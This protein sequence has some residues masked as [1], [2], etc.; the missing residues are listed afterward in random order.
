PKKKPGRGIRKEDRV[1]RYIIHQTHLLCLLVSVLTRHAVCDDPQ[2]QT[3]VAALLPSRLAEVF[4]RL[5][6]KI[7]QPFLSHMN[8]VARWWSRSLCAKAHAGPPPNRAK[9]SKP[10]RP[11]IRRAADVRT[12]F[13]GVG[14]AIAEHGLRWDPVIHGSIGDPET[15]ALGFV[16]L[17]RRMGV[18]ARLVASLHPVSLQIKRHEQAA[19]PPFVLW[20]E[21]CD[22][23][24]HTWM[25]VHVTQ[26]V[27][28]NPLVFDSGAA[29]D[30]QSQL[31]YIVACEPGR[32]V[33]DVTRRYCLLWGQKTAKLRLPPVAAGI[34]WWLR[35]LRLLSHD[36]QDHADD[37]EQEQFE[38]LSK[39]EAMPTTLAGFRDHPLY[40]IERDLRRH[41]VMHPAGERYGIG[42][43]REWVVY[44]RY[45][46]HETFSRE[47]W[48]RRGMRVRD[49]E[50]PAKRVPARAA[51]VRRQREIVAAQVENARTGMDDPEADP[52]MTALFGSWQ[53]EKLAPPP[54]L[55][56]DPLPRNAFGNFEAFHPNAIPIGAVHI[57]NPGA[58]KVAKRLGIEHVPVVVDF[59]FRSGHSHPVID[60]ILVRDAMVEVLES[61]ADTF[62][63]HTEAEAAKKRR[64]QLH[65]RWRYMYKAVLTRA[66]VMHQY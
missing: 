65:Q 24:S 28:N 14:A 48:A 57:R 21:V 63:E 39:N 4:Q 37:R 42:R 10:K 40:A 17:C 22:P 25:P 16:A 7:A 19:T 64:L 13:A 55:S 46:V 49:G 45:H 32:G 15:A 66:R 11:R 23:F 43:F 3:T 30:P 58:A 1:R 36:R 52:S 47:Q 20:A 50:A 31:S 2:L 12:A 35:T 6:P 56:G 26:G 51:T 61:A 59:S 60:G 33:K 27:V 9:P 5:R 34:S 29:S 38:T 54:L 18:R 53:T 62:T 8:L 41:E 44:P